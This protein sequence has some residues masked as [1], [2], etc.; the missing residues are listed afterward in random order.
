MVDRFDPALYNIFCQSKYIYSVKPRKMYMREKNAN[1]Q[2]KRIVRKPRK[3]ANKID[4]ASKPKLT[5][6]EKQAIKLK[7]QKEKDQAKIA[8]GELEPKNKERFYCNNKD[9]QAELIKWRDSSS[10]VE[11]RIISEKLGT[12]MMAIANKLLNH[13]SFRNYSVELKQD[14][15]SF[16]Y[17]KA[18]RGLKN[19]NFEFNNPFAW[20]T[21][22]AWNA[23]LSI[24]SRHYRHMNIKRDLL[25]KLSSELESYGRISPNTSLNKC[26]KQYIDYNYGSQ[27]NE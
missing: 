4:K 20:F 1:V 19:Y 9:L 17:F 22:C 27:D 16:F 7:K 12:M 26:I 13:S 6:A 21:Q 2:Q 5:L 23:F 25:E 3:T 18:I 24:I 15:A 8:R 14:M 10:I 11:E